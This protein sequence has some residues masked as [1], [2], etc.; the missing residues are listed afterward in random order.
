MAKRVRI[1]IKTREG[2]P[3]LFID[4][5]EMRYGQ[6]QNGL[7]YLEQYGYDRSSSLTDLARKYIAYRKRI[8]A[9]KLKPPRV[10]KRVH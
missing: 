5:V 7:Y 4:G 6:L 8:D 10:V 1:Q 2:R 3:R 9:R